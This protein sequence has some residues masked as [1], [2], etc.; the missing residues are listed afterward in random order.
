MQGI[1]LWSDA[2]SI[3]QN[4]CG[5]LAPVTP[6]AAALS[7]KNPTL[8]NV[9]IPIVFKQKMTCPS[10]ELSKLKYRIVYLLF[11]DQPNGFF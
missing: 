9:D 4:T 1:S 5:A 7:L 2:P 11:F 3:L 8:Q 6:L 10:F